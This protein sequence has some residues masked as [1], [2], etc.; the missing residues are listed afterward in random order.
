MKACFA[1]ESVPGE[2]C[3]YMRIRY[4]IDFV[5]VLANEDPL[6]KVSD[7]CIVMPQYTTGDP[8]PGVYEAGLED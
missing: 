4:E 1:G 8:L 6:V 5:M 2:T 3:M 7:F